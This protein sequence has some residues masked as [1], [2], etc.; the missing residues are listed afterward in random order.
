MQA[1]PHAARLHISHCCGALGLFLD[2]F[3]SGR[4]GFWDEDFAESVNFTGNPVVATPDVT[5]IPL[6][7]QDEFI[8]LASDGLW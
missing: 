3:W 1:S 6:N 8:I 5:E 2:C 7:E 4:G